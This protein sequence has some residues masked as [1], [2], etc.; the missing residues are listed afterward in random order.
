[1]LGVGK[2]AE[3]VLGVPVYRKAD[4]LVVV[5]IIVNDHDGRASALILATSDEY[6]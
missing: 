2:A 5:I 4:S 1:V 6:G 3:I